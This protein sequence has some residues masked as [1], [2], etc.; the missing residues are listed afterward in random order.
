M[1]TDFEKIL[2]RLCGRRKSPTELMADLDAEYS[3]QHIRMTLQS[4]HLR[5]LMERTREGRKVL[6]RTG[7]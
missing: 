1:A 4:L 5:G 7:D 6:Y 2:M 3:Y